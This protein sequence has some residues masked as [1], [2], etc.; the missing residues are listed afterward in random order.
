MYI[1][2]SGNI[3]LTANTTTSR[4]EILWSATQAS[5]TGRAQ[6]LPAISVPTASVS[7]RWP[8]IICRIIGYPVGTCS[9]LFPA[10]C[11]LDRSERCS[12]WSTFFPQ[13]KSISLIYAIVSPFRSSSWPVKWYWAAVEMNPSTPDPPPLRQQ[14]VS[15]I[16]L[17]CITVNRSRCPQSEKRWISASII[18]L[19]FLK[20]HSAFRQCS[21]SWNAALV[22]HRIC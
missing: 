11:C 8:F 19:I 4:K 9:P 3:W 10:V 7:H 22:R 2:A 17:I 16:I 5:C 14:T 20:M 1:A 15:G 6:N 18:C 13:T 21:M 12:A